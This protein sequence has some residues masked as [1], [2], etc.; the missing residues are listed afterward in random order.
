MIKTILYFAALALILIAYFLPNN[1]KKTT[2][3]LSEDPANDAL[4][5]D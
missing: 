1:K 5:E 4:K 2:E 3:V